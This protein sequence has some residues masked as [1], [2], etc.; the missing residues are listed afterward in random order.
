MALC[1]LYN[2]PKEPDYSKASVTQPLSLL[3]G[4]QA[5]SSCSWLSS[6]HLAVYEQSSEEIRERCYE[7]K[8]R[9]NLLMENSIVW[10][11]SIGHHRYTCWQTHTC[12]VIASHNVQPTTRTFQS[13]LTAYNTLMNCFPVIICGSHLV[14]LALSPCC[15]GGIWKASFK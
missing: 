9:L 4:G 7:M 14:L 5:L 12:W 13:S 3:V 6:G 11:F 1:T 15:S 10:S 8:Q 2:K